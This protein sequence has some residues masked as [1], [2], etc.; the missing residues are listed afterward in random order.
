ML[1]FAATVTPPSGEKNQPKKSKTQKKQMTNKESK[2]F[3]IKLN[4][5]ENLNYD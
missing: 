1:K 3:L 4:V 2:E 5:N